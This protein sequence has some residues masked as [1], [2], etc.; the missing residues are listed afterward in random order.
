MSS[1][2]VRSLRRARLP[3]RFIQ[4]RL[5][6]ERI[7]SHISS[8]YTAIAVPCA[9]FTYTIN[10]I[11]RLNLNFRKVAKKGIIPNAGAVF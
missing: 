11:V 6:N 5:V 8:T 3:G 4:A 2:F 7:T 9:R 10:A 1:S